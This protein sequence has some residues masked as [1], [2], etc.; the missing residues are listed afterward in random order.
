MW[1]VVRVPGT[2]DGAAILRGVLSEWKAGIDAHDPARVAAAFTADAVFQGLRPYSV[3]R[4]GVA[5]Y[6]DS[7]PLGMTVDYRL[8]EVRQVGETA[9]LGYL[10][11]D[12][13]YRDRDPVGVTIGV[14]AVR[15]DDG[16]RLGYYQAGLA[17]EGSRPS[18]THT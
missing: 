6:Y 18:G 17:P 13:S 10:A 16:W 14:L 15:T 8:L 12:F 11:A 9:V 4:P 7:Q 1:T 5:E 3:G 2:E